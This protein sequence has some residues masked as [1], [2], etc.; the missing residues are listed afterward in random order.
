M[1]VI[2][3]ALILH[4]RLFIGEICRC[5]RFPKAAVL[6]SIRDILSAYFKQIFKDGLL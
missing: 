6:L 4:F 2:G 1:N 3:I 5:L